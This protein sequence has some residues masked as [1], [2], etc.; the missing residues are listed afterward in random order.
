MWLFIIEGSLTVVLGI[1]GFFWLPA[2]PSTAWFL[3][4]QERAF[5]DYRHLRDGSVS[6]GDQFRLQ[7]CFR[8]WRDWKF[9]M[10]CIISF[11]YPVAFSTTANFLPL[12][13]QRLGFG[14]V[15]T[16]LLTVPPNLVG[17][18]VLLIVT[19]SSDKKRE[20]MLH[21]VAALSLSLVGLIL[22]AAI[23]P[24]KLGRDIGG[25]YFACF[26]LCSGA[27][28]PSCLVHSWHNNNNPQ[29]TSRAATTGLL[30]GLGNLAG[31]ISAGTFRTTYAPRY[32]PTLAATASCNVICIIFT[33]GLGIWMR[34]ENKRKDREQNIVLRAGDVHMSAM[35]D[36]GVQDPRWRYFV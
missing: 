30:V 25:A 27:Y 18:V 29:E 16:N 31:I 6:I 13:L 32:I 26:L 12:I 1:I 19:R 22:L 35:R 17:F 14:T 24:D 10:W 33:L 34:K 2:S 7:D 5:A 9:A 11:T 36:F 4:D 23:P 8:H 15:I 20:R 3:T 28:I 21:I